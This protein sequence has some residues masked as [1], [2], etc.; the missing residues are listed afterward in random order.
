MNLRI[1]TDH[2]LTDPHAIA[3][4][5]RIQEERM[6]N[7]NATDNNFWAENLLKEFKEKRERQAKLR[8]TLVIYHGGKHE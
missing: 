8:P 1:P 6:M 5:L 7:Q 3:A 4:I 2:Y